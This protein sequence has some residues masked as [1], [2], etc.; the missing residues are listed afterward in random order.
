MNKNQKPADGVLYWNKLTI[1]PLGWK[2]S[3]FGSPYTRGPLGSDGTR[4]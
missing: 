4:R 1:T 2:S 3:E